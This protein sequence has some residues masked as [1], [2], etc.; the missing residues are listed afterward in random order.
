MRLRTFESFW[1]LKNG[2]LNSY[3]SLEKNIS[4]EIIVIGGGITGAL[5]SDA[6]ISKNYKVTLLD[7]RDIGQGSTSAT[8]SMLQYEIDT[9]LHKLADIMGEESAAECYK[10]GIKA[11]QDLGKLVGLKKIDCGFQKKR[12][13]Y[14]AH[15]KKAAEDL[16]KEF[17][18]RNK[19][20]LGVKWLTPAIVKKQY[21]IVSE[22]AI[23]SG[24]AASVDAYKLTHELI[25]LNVKKGMQVFDQTDISE[26]DCRDDGVTVITKNGSRVDGK[27]IIFCSGFEST[28]LL[29]EK[30]AKLFYTYACVSEQNI[31]INKN[32]KDTL[33][34]DTQDPYL[35]LRT[36]DDGRLLIGGE[37]SSNNISLF[38]QQKK[39]KKSTTLITKLGKLIPGLH[40]VEDF[41]WAGTF[42]STKDGLP[43]I[44]AS[45]EFANALFVLGF[46]GNGITFSVQ[47]RSIITDLLAGKKNKLAQYYR[48]KR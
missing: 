6:L 45:P 3:P 25:R 34:W 17:E 22:G 10:A 43:Y 32:I 30:I 15:N 26:F 23:L 16:Y 28:S 35:Y 21:D 31:A 38:Q 8:T 41:S 48:F 13:L 47:G 5:I 4:T 36:T 12:S 24:T 2:L 18:I 37:D 14:C 39:E 11:I 1:L 9:P 42:G 29:K 27:K 46:G 40:F 44:G 20:K 33:I 7:K 19:Y